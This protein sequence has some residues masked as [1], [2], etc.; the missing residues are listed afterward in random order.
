MYT[1]PVALRKWFVEKLI[2][3]LE[4]EVEASKPKR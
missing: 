4:A 2:K 1:L 3:Q